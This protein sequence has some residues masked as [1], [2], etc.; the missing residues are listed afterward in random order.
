MADLRDNTE[1]PTPVNSLC[2]NLLLLLLASIFLWTSTGLSVSVAA[3]IETMEAPF[4]HALDNTPLENRTPLILIHGI[5]PGRGQYDNWDLYVAAF[6]NNAPF[7]QQYKV[8]RYPLLG[9]PENAALLT[10]A[11]EQ[12]LVETR[13]QNMRLLAHSMGGVLLRNLSGGH[14]MQHHVDR[15][16]TISTPFHGTPLT[17]K[18]WIV[19]QKFLLSPLRGLYKLAYKITRKR[20]PTFMQDYCW[21]NFDASMPEDVSS[22]VSDE[23]HIWKPAPNTQWVVY[24]SFYTDN[25][26]AQRWL[27]QELNTPQTLA[28]TLENSDL[29]GAGLFGARRRLVFAREKLSRLSLKKNQATDTDTKTYSVMSFNDGVSPINSQLWLG[30]FAKNPDETFIS[31]LARSQADQKSLTRLFAGLDHRDWMD[32]HTRY[33]NP[34][35][36][37]DHRVYDLLHPEREPK[38]T[39]E[40][41]IHDLLAPA[42]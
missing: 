6:Q 29:R 19:N 40:W 21:D 22:K 10:V 1:M 8:Y 38:T 24:G 11:L 39:V 25:E 12:F 42:L 5:D 2:K 41:V 37:Q 9:V 31:A 17:I 23:C 26:E 4:L 32:G 27:T 15:I 34:E 28:A 18:P 20:H 33:K 30:R 14:L 7:Q 3:D 16:I 36:S 13:T 35:N